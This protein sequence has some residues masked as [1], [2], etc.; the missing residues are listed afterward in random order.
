MV[1]LSLAYTGTLNPGKGVYRS[2]TFRDEEE[3][4]DTVL[5]VTQ[6]EQTGARHMFPCIDEPSSKV[7][8]QC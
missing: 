1:T 3:A 4:K 8:L 5:L 6:L 7:N 2:S